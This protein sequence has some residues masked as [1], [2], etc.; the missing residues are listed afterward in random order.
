MVRITQ[1]L[2]SDQTLRNLQNNILRMARLQDQLST[3]RRINR[4]ADD[5]IDFP[6]S[7]SM[8]S[9]ISQGR[10]YLSNLNGARTNLELTETTMGSL[11]EVLQNIR[12]LAV[13][14]ANNADTPARITIANQVQEMLGQVMDLANANYNG[15]YIFGGSVTKQ[16]SFVARD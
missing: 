1:N 3:G 2:I 5:P 10:S 15:Q 13:Q 16:E 12:T 8:R 11:T 6:S 4:S 9:S 7:L 14:G